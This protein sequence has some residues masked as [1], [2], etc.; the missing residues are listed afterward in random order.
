MLGLA[1]P[2]IADSHVLLL[3]APGP[4]L[5]FHEA[6]LEGLHRPRI[7]VAFSIHRGLFLRL[8]RVRGVHVVGG[9][10]PGDGTQT[11]HSYAVQLLVVLL[12]MPRTGVSLQA[13][14]SL[15]FL[16]PQDLN[17]IPAIRNP[18]P[19]AHKHELRSLFL[20]PKPQS[21]LDPPA[22]LCNLLQAPK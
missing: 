13:W 19:W 16:E 6:S 2:P 18:P 15:Q 1:L 8:G 22:L 4:T 20:K 14:L 9:Q 17:L 10:G 11:R 3:F 5:S 7:K 21:H 12:G